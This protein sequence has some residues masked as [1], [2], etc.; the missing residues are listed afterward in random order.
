MFSRRL[1]SHLVA[2]ADN[3][4]ST[5]IS[6]C[7]VCTQAGVLVADVRARRVLANHLISSM[8]SHSINGGA[9]VAKRKKERQ[10]HPADI[11][12]DISRNI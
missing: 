9:T 6:T 12:I 5:G 10:Y 4:V 3:V 1:R 8:Q 11:Q 2:V 7:G